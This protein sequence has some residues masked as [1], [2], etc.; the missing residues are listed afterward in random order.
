MKKPLLLGHRGFS[1]V[2]PENTPLAFRK[3]AETAADGIE[4]DVHLCKTGELVL[5]HDERVDR[6]SDGH[7][8]IKEQ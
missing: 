6:T 3:V 1:G 5:C 8:F 7:G 2:Y 4:T